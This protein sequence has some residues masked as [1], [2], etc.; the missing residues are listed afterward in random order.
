MFY[1]SRGANQVVTP[2]FVSA[3][4]GDDT[5]AFISAGG[6]TLQIQTGQELP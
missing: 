4:V 5:I 1:P 6:T 3:S 2:N